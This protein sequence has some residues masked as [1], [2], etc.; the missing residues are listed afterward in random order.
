MKRLLT[1]FALAAILLIPAA[2]SAQEPETV[3]VLVCHQD[4]QSGNYSAVDVSVHSVDDANG[5]NGHGDHEGD[6]WKGFTFDG[7]EYPGQ[8]EGFFDTH[9]GEDCS[10]NEPE[11]QEASISI[12]L[13]ACRWDG[14]KSL[15]TASVTITG[16]ATV[17]IEGP[18]G[19]YVL[20]SS[21]ELVLEAGDYTWS[22]VAGDGYKIVGPSE[23]DFSVG[24]CKPGEPPR[25]HHEPK[26]GPEAALPIGAGIAFLTSLGLGVFGIRRMRKG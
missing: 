14:E 18:G 21:D 2:A 10:P 7:V 20:T 5:L 24:T 11:E 4:G 1:Y 12:E 19:P 17:T 22:A 9:S 13:S 3:K 15:A 16:E 8:N 6:A 25:P 26:T 23:G